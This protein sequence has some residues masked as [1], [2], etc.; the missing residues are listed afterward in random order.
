M[1]RVRRDGAGRAALTAEPDERRARFAALLPAVATCLTARDS[2]WRTLRYPL[3]ELTITD[4]Q[5]DSWDY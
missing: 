4:F 2:P 5:E 3:P 1:A